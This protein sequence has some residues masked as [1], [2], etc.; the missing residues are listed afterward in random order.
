MN[1]NEHEGYN[2]FRQW[3][4]DF[5]DTNVRHHWTWHELSEKTLEEMSWGI[6]QAEA[7]EEFYVPNIRRNDADFQK[8][9]K[10]AH[11]EFQ[12]KLDSWKPK[13]TENDD[14][15]LRMEWQ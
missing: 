12:R 9:L 11:T 2:Y 14:N 4:I 5:Y 6:F 13:K 15:K 10:A 7:R 1:K 8:G 3:V